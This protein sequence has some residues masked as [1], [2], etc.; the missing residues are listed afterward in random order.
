VLVSAI[1]FI[2]TQTHIH[3]HT[4]THTQFIFKIR[5]ISVTDII[6]YDSP[7]DCMLLY[8]KRNEALF[9]NSEATARTTLQDSRMYVVCPD[10]KINTAYVIN[11]TMSLTNYSTA[12]TI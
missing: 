11:I 6:M 3:K 2:S 8:G 9:N 10:G 7:A 1:P 4:H 12:C 5:R